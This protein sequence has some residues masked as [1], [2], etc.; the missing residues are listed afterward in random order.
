MKEITDIPIELLHMEDLNNVKHPSL[1]DKTDNYNIFITRIPVLT[2]KL[3]NIS[4]GF[5]ITEN[6]SHFFNINTESFELLEDK[7]MSIHS[8]IDKQTDKLL[9]SYIKYQ[10]LVLDMEEN[11]YANNTD[12]H[13]LNT[14]LNL[15]LDILKIEKVLIRSTNTLEDF[16]RYYKRDSNFPLNHFIDLHEHLDRII[17]SA[18]LQLSKL[19]DLY[20]FYNA[21]SNDKMNKMIYVLTI[22]SAIFLPLNLVVGFFGMNTTGLPFSTGENGTYY[23]IFFIILLV[24]IT[25]VLILFWRKKVEK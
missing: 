25:S 4:L 21:K 20:N 19:D 11:L 18:T 5:I 16:I 8:L 9:K 23:A 1:F 2:D 3:S 15:K 17:R 22:I 6:E 14:W 12:S 7:Y 24:I 10:E 13:F